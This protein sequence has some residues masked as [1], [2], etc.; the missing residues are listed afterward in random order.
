MASPTAGRRI[1]VEP[2]FVDAEL[3]ADFPI[4]DDRLLVRTPPVEEDRLLPP[5]STIFDCVGRTSLDFEPLAPIL[6]ED[7]VDD[8]LMGTDVALDTNFPCCIPEDD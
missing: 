5:A 4:D 8:P 7:D 2:L 3:P 1:Y 6:T